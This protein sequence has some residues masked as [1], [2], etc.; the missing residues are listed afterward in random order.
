MG[1]FTT[2]TSYRINALHGSNTASVVP[3]SIYPRFAQQVITNNNEQANLSHLILL[4][5]EAVLEVICVSLPGY[6]VARQ[7][8]LNAEH[9]RFLANLNISLFSPC[10]SKLI[11]F[12]FL[13]NTLIQ[14]VF[15]KLASQLT[16]EKLI[17]LAIIPLV[18]AVQTAVSF[19]V[20]IAVAKCFGFGKRPSNFVTA[21]GV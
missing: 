6:I 19:L 4:I 1:L 3:S 16:A 12:S 17:D 9:Q 13:Y 20:S 21:M 2:P 18:F 15:T 8:L 5:C 7:G 11:I 10:L 14:V